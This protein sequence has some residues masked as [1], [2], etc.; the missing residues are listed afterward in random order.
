[1]KIKNLSNKQ[2][3]LIEM[4]II[5]NISTNHKM[6]QKLKIKG[7]RIAQLEPISLLSGYLMSRIE[8]KNPPIK[9]ISLPATVF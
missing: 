5:T 7:A 3:N 6:Y 1:M 4:L 8:E 9:H 2:L